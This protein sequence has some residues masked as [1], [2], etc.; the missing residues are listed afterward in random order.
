MYRMPD[1]ASSDTINIFDDSTRAT[2][3]SHIY[4]HPNNRR[5]SPAERALIIEWLTGAQKETYLPEGDQ[6]TQP[7]PCS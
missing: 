1:G 3:L 2:F 7:C 6:Q 4:E 5:V